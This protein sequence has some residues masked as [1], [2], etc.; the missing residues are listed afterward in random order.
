MP[1]KKLYFPKNQ[2]WVLLYLIP[3][4]LVLWF[5]A[6]FSVNVPIGDEWALV[7][8]LE[9]AYTGQA[10]FN[11]FF[12]QHNEHRLLFPKI[13]FITLAF[14][15]KWNIEYEQYFSIFLASVTFGL[16]YKLSSEQVGNQGQDIYWHLANIL[17]CMLI[18]SLVQHENWLWG[19]QLSWFLIN[20]CVIVAIFL[21]NSTS[22]VNWSVQKRISLSALS[23]FIASF[24]LAHGVLAWLAVIPS[25]ASI[26]GSSHQKIRNILIWLGLF[27]A[28]VAIYLIGYHKPSYHPSTFFFLKHPLIAATYFFNFL[29]SSLA[30]SSNLAII[31]GIIIFSLFLALILY[32]IRNY[33]LI[34]QASPWLSLGLFALLFSLLTTVGRAGF[35]I[36]QANASRYTSTS[37]LLVISIIQ[38]WRLYLCS[39]LNSRKLNLLG[40]KSYQ[41]FSVIL[42]IIFII[43][44]LQIIHIGEKTWKQKQNSKI[45]LDLLYF[46]DES[47]LVNEVSNSCLKELFPAPIAL[48]AYAESL[49][50]IGLR[51]FPKNIAFINDSTQVDGVI[52]TPPSDKLVVVKRKNNLA[53]AGWAILPEPREAP[54]IVL[55]SLGD[56]QT[57]FNSAY[58]NLNSPDVAKVLNSQKYLHSRWIANF[59]PMSMPLGETTVKAWVYDSTG[60]R[61]VKLKNELKIKVEE[62]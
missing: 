23:C 15:S 1:S 46:M 22:L 13:I 24:S 43:N 2:V 44:S 59:P 40:G 41:I 28:S 42:A 34:P 29:G 31:T 12:A 51:T 56:K 16:I 10:T 8:I 60:K 37:V 61:F 25:V 50:K 48:K 26:P 6:S 19:F 53:L 58:I 7:T 38:L 3:I 47:Y 45:C 62:G 5:V 49:T 14:I 33:Q 35:G 4:L 17:T 36:E 20:V 18:F 27:I 57:F 9:K 54:K 21:I 11:D 30:R 39:N 52:D 32:L 55:F